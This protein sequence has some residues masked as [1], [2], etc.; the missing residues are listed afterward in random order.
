MARTLDATRIAGSPEG[1]DALSIP[2]PEGEAADW[3]EKL[4]SELQAGD[5]LFI[6][7]SNKPESKVVH[8]IIWL[9]KIGVGPD[10]TPLVL[11]STGGG[12]KD[13]NGVAIPC[14]IHMRPFRKGSWYHSA[15]SHAHR[16]VRL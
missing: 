12:V 9:G 7:G 13:S 6:K 4:C 14:G 15:F 10:A 5:L 11:D 1:V 3:Y 8:V 16:I 2:R